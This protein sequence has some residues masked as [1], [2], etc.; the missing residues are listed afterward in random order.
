MPNPESLRNQ[1]F[2]TS[3]KRF[4]FSSARLLDTEF[5]QLNWIPENQLPIK[6]EIDAKLTGNMNLIQYLNPQQSKRLANPQNQS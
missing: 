3:G 1:G 5:F 4:Q 2:V 6:C